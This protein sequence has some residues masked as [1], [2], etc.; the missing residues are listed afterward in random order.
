MDEESS[1][2]YE[3]GATA[4]SE[5]TLRKGK[6]VLVLGT[7]SSTTITATQVLVQTTG[8]GAE[9]ATAATVI[10]FARVHSRRQSRSVR[11]RPATPKGQGPS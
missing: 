6:H 8:G 11:S 2:K 1:T 3:K 9:P 10:P 4:I 5:S 7:V